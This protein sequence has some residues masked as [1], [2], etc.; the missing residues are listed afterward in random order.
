MSAEEVLEELIKKVEPGEKQ[1][2]LNEL[3]FTL[4]T[5]KH[6]INECDF[7]GF[8]VSTSDLVYAYQR[9]LESNPTVEERQ[10]VLEAILR[11]LHDESQ[12]TIRE[13][14]VCLTKEKVIPKLR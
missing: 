10:K 13:K 8:P 14:C 11:F 6:Q 9:F 12:K 4:T 2:W 1:R 5:I 3:R 7:A